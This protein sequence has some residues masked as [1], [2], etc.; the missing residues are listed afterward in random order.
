M[1]INKNHKKMSITDWHANVHLYKHIEM[2][3]Q[4]AAA[5]KGMDRELFVMDMDKG[6]L[7]Q[8][9]K[10]YMRNVRI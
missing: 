2:N 5:N 6:H 4:E 3:K 1:D 8:Q 7:L 10:M 9:R